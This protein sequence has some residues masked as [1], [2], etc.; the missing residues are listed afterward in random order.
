MNKKK[1]PENQSNFPLCTGNGRGIK[2]NVFLQDETIWLTQKAIGN[3]FEKSKATINKHLKKIYTEG[4][5]QMD[6]TVRN[7]R[8]VQTKGLQQIVAQNTLIPK[9]PIGERRMA[10]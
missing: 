3:L 2:V 1:F 4:K 9:H 8:T 10:V 6:S 7:F 5:L